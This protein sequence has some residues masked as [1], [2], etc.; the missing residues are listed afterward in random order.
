MA[1][2]TFMYVYVAW[3]AVYFISNKD[4]VNVWQKVLTFGG[5]G[6]ATIIVVIIVTYFA[7]REIKKAMDNEETSSI[8]QKNV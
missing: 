4:T 3:V 2:G 1:P 7:R 6:V 8:I 5:G